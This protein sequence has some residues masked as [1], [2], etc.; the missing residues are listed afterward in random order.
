M[1]LRLKNGRTTTIIAATVLVVTLNTF[2]FSASGAWTSTASVHTPRDGHTATLLPNG[3]VVIAGGENN[4]QALNSSE[5]YSPTFGS[6]T[7]SGNLN[8]ARSNANA[9]LLPN[10]STLVAGGCVSHCLGGTTATEELFH[11]SVGGK[12]SRSPVRCRPR[13]PISAWWSWPAARFSRLVDVP[14]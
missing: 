3:N 14:A 2:A 9:L 11:N 1:E 13:A 4:D 5:V 6:W 8:V 10:G 7:A 12:W